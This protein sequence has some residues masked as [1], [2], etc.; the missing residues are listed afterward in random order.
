M[1]KNAITTEEIMTDVKVT[2]V[3]TTTSVVRE[4]TTTEKVMETGTTSAIAAIKVKAATRWTILTQTLI[5]VNS[6]AVTPSFS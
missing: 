1:V 3:T 2:T 5:I 6:I 4:I